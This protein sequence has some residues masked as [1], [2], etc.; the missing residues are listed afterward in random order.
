[1]YRSGLL[2]PI[3]GLFLFAIVA[4]ALCV[5]PPPTLYRVQVGQEDLLALQGELESQGWGPM[6]LEQEPGGVRLLVGEA[7]YY[8]DAYL[9]ARQ[10]EK[11]YG[12][13]AS[14]VSVPNT[15][16]KA[17]LAGVRGPIEKVFRQPETHMS[18]VPDAILP[19]GDPLVERIQS[20][21][22]GSDKL[23]YRRA[24]ME[25]IHP[26]PDSDV[27]KGY[28]LT[29][30]GIFELL[31]RNFDESLACLRKVAD[32]EV[33]A[34]RVDRIKAMRRVA[35]ILH[36]QKDRLGAYRAY[37][38][39]ERFTASNL[40]R[41]MAKVEC[42]GVLME[43]AREEGDRQFGRVSPGMSESAGA[44]QRRGPGLSAVSGDGGTD[45]SGELL[46]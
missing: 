34:T 24:L 19:Q 45:V 20:L 42:A 38:E 3:M 9:C 8:A 36:E 31:E 22:G 13:P 1:M 17:T 4:E 18:E 37:R 41:V 2:S 12:L 35:W 14:V 28:A 5:E 40:V 11:T 16:A 44:G 30:K 6:S 27:R 46:L 33:A 7:E 21:E 26:L 43:F 23:A 29:R 32:G 25:A 10:L 15:E 39:V